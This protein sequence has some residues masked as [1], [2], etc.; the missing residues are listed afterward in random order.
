M[1]PSITEITLYLNELYN[2][3]DE[4]V[5]SA[6]RLLVKEMDKRTGENIAEKLA[7][8]SDS[9]DSMQE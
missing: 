7:E 3:R 8:S 5:R 9:D 1:I 4:S 6:A 2:C